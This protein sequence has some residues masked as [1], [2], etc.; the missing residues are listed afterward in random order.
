[1]ERLAHLHILQ[2]V[3]SLQ[4]PRLWAGKPAGSRAVFVALAARILG[5][6]ALPASVSGANKNG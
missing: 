6:G 2:K 5:A 4:I 1:M 3:V